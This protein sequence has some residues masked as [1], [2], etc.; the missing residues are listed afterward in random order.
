VFGSFGKEEIEFWMWRENDA[1]SVLLKLKW[2]GIF[3][4]ESD[5][6]IGWLVCVKLE[7]LAFIVIGKW[8][9]P[10]A[11]LRVLHDNFQARLG[12]QKDRS[13]AES[14]EF[15]RPTWVGLPSFKRHKPNEFMVSYI[16]LPLREARME[17]QAGWK[18]LKSPQNREF[19]VTKLKRVSQRSV[20][21]LE[22]LGI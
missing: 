20:G 19:C 13:M 2:I 14:V 21:I 22:L 15:R 11:S 17:P 10:W 3:W 7:K 1:Q 5:L 9:L 8:S 6:E 16:R 18:A 12:E 4:I